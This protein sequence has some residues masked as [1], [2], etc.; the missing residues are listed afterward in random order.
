MTESPTAGCRSPPGSERRAGIE[1]SLEHHFCRRAPAA[2]N[3]IAGA[4][5][6][7]VL[8]GGKR[9][10]PV[11]ALA[12]AEAVVTADLLNPK[13][14]R[15]ADACGVRLELIH[16][17]SLIHDDLPAI[18]NDTLRRGRPTLHVVHGEA[19][20]ILAGDGLLA[21]AFG[22]SRALHELRGRS[23]VRKL[24]SSATS[25]TAAGPAEWWR[26]GHRPSGCRTGDGRTPALDVSVDSETC[27]PA[28]P[29]HSSALGVA[30][31][32]WPAPTDGSRGRRF[33]ADLGLAFQM[34]T[35]CW[36]WKGRRQRSA[37]PPA[38][39]RRPAR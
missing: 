7:S 1:A 33:A 20:A 8:A 21:A 39:M 38:R 32:S 36:M 4:M 17:Y 23:S 19:M 2:P 30:G 34:W 9:L 10:R 15:L 5:R 6:Y 11:L 3:L 18:D 27:T 37:R 24:A 12:A 13:R 26:S 29:G 14:A 22:S 16:T 28:R 25:P 35:M 31:G